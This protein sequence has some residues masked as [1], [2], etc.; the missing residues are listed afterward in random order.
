MQPNLGG[1]D[2]ESNRNE[3]PPSRRMLASGALRTWIDSRRGRHSGFELAGEVQTIAA[4]ELDDMAE[5]E[6]LMLRAPAEVTWPQRDHAPRTS[7]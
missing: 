2:E 5:D 1:C 4:E 3:L 7:P 6:A